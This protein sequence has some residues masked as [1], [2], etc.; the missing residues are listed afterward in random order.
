M[1]RSEK[2]S[3]EGGSSNKVNVYVVWKN[4]PGNFI[5]LLEVSRKR[6]IYFGGKRKKEKKLSTDWIQALLNFEEILKV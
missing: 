5:S 4:V 2:K 3:K 6:I 1:D